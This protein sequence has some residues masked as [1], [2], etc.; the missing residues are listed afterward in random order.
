MTHVRVLI[1]I[2]FL[3]V[4]DIVAQEHIFV[5]SFLTWFKILKIYIEVEFFWVVM[6]CSVEAAWSSETSVYY[7]ITRPHGTENL[8]SNI[9][10][11]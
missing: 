4:W 5:S 8:T 9:S 7:N 3:C 11:Y 2:Y 1:Y 6:P 10:T